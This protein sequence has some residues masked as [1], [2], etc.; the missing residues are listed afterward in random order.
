MVKE[1]TPALKRRSLT[2]QKAYSFYKSKS[3]KRQIKNT[4][5]LTKYN[6]IISAFYKKIGDKM[7]EKRGGVFLPGFGYFVVL[8]N[9]IKQVL[10]SIYKTEGSIL[11]NAH[12]NSMVYHPAFI[13]TC[14]DASM[15][16]FVMDR[17]FNRDFNKRL[18][19]KIKSGMKFT[20]HYGLLL[21]IFKNKKR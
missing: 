19:L 18:G 1:K 4:P 12:S 7:L 3:K 6:K 5:N 15:K 13:P 20:N 8:L 2:D 10:D 11:L 21:S 16:S 14:T 17:Y 9:P